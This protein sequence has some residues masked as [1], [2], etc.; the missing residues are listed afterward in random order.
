MGFEATN[1][2]FGKITDMRRLG[3]GYGIGLAAEPAG[4]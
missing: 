2:Q 4:R 3:G 1:R